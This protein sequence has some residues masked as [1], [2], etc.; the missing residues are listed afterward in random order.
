MGTHVWS[1][2]AHMS[3]VSHMRPHAHMATQKQGPIPH[4]RR[5][6]VHSR[7]CLWLCLLVLCFSLARHAATVL[8][9]AGHN[10][11]HSQ[12]QEP[13][14]P[15]CRTDIAIVCVLSSSL[16]AT[17][18]QSMQKLCC[19]VLAVALHSVR[20]AVIVHPCSQRHLRALA[21][22]CNACT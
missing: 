17:T 10:H 13:Y 22:R 3:V 18:T 11:S 4:G 2:G 5:F 19:H 16:Q 14:M 20:C 1:H 15:Y 8:L 21:R 6:V 7:R 9:S 12:D